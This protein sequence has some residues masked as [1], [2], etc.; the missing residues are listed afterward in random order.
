[1]CAD[2]REAVDIRASASA[3]LLLAAT[4]T[5]IGRFL[6]AVIPIEP[7]DPLLVDLARRL[8]NAAT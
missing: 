7:D 5:P 1:M 3:A 4:V 2:C 8:D 6:R